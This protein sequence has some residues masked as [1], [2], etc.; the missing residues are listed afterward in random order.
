MYTYLAAG[1]FLFTCP[2]GVA[3]GFH[4]IPVAEGR[5]DAFTPL[6]TRFSE[7][8]QPLYIVYDFS[9]KLME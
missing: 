8:E 3:L 6:V 7:E 4:V 9:C 2:H 5:N 1:I